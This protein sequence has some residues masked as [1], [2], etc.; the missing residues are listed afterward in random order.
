MS[1]LSQKDANSA[2]GSH[3]IRRTDNRDQRL[4]NTM[5][6]S[7]RRWLLATLSRRELDVR[8]EEW[9]HLRFSYSQFGEDLV[10]MSL[11][12]EPGGFY[13]DVG[14]YHPVT[15]SNTF[16]FYRRGWRGI[17][18]DGNPDCL[19]TFARRRPR[20]VRVHAALSDR[21][22]EAVFEVHPAGTTSQL[23]DTGGAVLQPSPAGG[24]QIRLRTR[25]L[26]AV[27]D[28]HLPGGTR[29][30]FLSIDCEHEDLAVLK[31]NDW[32]RY[33]ARV[34]SVEDWE[35]EPERSEICRLL[36]GLGYAL[37]ATVGIGRIFR[38]ERSGSPGQG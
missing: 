11:L 38:D 13:V 30:D 19:H 15:L 6:F 25:T 27:L 36:R 2:G 32:T 14:A 31:S 9:K 18:I 3:A 35:T 34:V 26:R 12:P 33:R 1:Q 4:K 8:Q 23:Q 29:V 21:E 20:D 24:R 5:G 10:A 17:V 28:E 7:L 37:V 22:R 16:H